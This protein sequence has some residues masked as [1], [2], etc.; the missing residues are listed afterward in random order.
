MSCLRLRPWLP[1]LTWLA[2]AFVG[3]VHLNVRSV[4]C[5]GRTAGRED[6]ASCA[7]KELDPAYLRHW[8][9]E[10]QQPAQRRGRG[11]RRRPDAK[12]RWKCNSCGRW[13]E[14]ATFYLT[15]QKRPRSRCRT[16]R[17][18]QAREYDRS[19]R[20][21]IVNLLKH[22]K[23]GAIRRDQEFSLT[24][25]TIVNMIRTQE[26]RCAYSGVQM[27]IT[28]PNS[29]WRMSLERVD[30]NK[31]YTRENCVLIAAEFNTWDQSRKPGVDPTTVEGTAQWSRA[32]VQQV[33]KL[34]LQNI[35]LTELDSDIETARKKPCTTKKLP[36]PSKADGGDGRLVWCI[37]C[38]N[39][40]ERACFSRQAKKKNGL[41]SY[42]R[43]CD[44]ELQHMRISTLRGHLSNLC[45]LARRRDQKCSLDLSMLLKML[46]Q[47][48]GRCYYSGIPLQYKK[49]HADWRLSLERLD[50]ALGYTKEN[51][52][53][54]CAEFNTPDNSRNKAVEEVFGTAQ[55]SRAKVEHVW[56]CLKD[57]QETSISSAAH[58]VPERS[59]LCKP[60]SPSRVA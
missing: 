12:G 3:P 27:E 32:K 15:V 19:P 60:E 57:L 17:M 10:A 54:V 2:A 58:A 34:R 30:N 33:N 52:V 23:A 49:V 38:L 50:N 22:A 41:R 18:H 40:Q 55:W 59:I 45:C 56:G 5:N 7:P 47:Q 28:T 51:T 26:G 1:W 9:A 44:K 24:H 20:G 8:L 31:G 4:Q 13:L 39:W 14:A 25:Q 48:E 29:H 37:R 53:L 6:A 21:N 36:P 46:K 11:P 35:D 16:C 43:R 42:C